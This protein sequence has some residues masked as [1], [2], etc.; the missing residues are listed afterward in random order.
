M[1][2]AEAPV[3]L[4]VI[5]AVAARHGSYR[6]LLDGLARQVVTM[7]PGD[8]A[9]ERLREGD[10]AAILLHLDDAD[11]RGVSDDLANILA[12]R[13]ALSGT[14][15]IVISAQAPDLDEDNRSPPGLLAYVPAAF[16][17][18]LIPERVSCLLEL[19]RVRGEL[20]RRDA[21]INMLA[22]QMEQLM[23][24]AAEERHT[25]D[26]LRARV[27]EQIHRSKNL[28]TI[29]QSVAR[30]TISDGREVSE[31]REAL[32]GRLRALARAYH[33]VTAADGAGTE[34]AEVVE[35]ELADIIQRITVS[36]PPARLAGSVVQTF[37]L[38]LHELAVNA[39]EHG[40][41]RSPEGSVAVGWTFFEQGS[42]R[43]L[44]MAWT[45]R[46]GPP[47]KAP[48]Q[49]GFGL[50]LVSS[51]AGAGAAA[52]NI[53]FETGGLVCRMRIPQEVIVAG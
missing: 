22:H 36:G 45:E 21:Q 24:A 28:L 2:G 1:T 14:P 30:R 51:F 8:A 18:D 41:L 23:A 10:F 13:D 48:S 17:A 20:A 19:A 32:M 40:A 39:V 3:D 53:M 9:R 26:A 27:G 6:D 42:D 11:D 34:I 4:L 33:L 31:S 50:T 38:A 44:E 29:M 52:P 25:S 15:V 5:D 16:T 12:S 35:A 49:Y 47:P 43:Y 37:T 46:G 7:V